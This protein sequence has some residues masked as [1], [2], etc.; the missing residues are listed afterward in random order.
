[1]RMWSGRGLDLV[2]TSLSSLFLSAFDRD[3]YMAVTNLVKDQPDHAKRI[4]QFAIEAIQQANM[5]LIDLEDPSLGHV[6]IRVGFHSGPVVAN[7]VGSRNPRFCL[8][9]DTGECGGIQCM[10]S[11]MDDSLTKS[12]THILSYCTPPQSTRP[13]GWKATARRIAFIAVSGPPSS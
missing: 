11:L 9:G 10:L 13:R 4:A 2:L 12:C 1:M 3:A 6:N 5:T 7:V 8:F